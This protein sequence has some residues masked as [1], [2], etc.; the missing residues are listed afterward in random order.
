MCVE[1]SELARQRKARGLTRKKFAEL[2]GI[3]PS[4]LGLVE[5]GHVRPWP[6]L[7]ADAARLLGVGEGEL[8]RQE[9]VRP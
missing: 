4:S 3:A 1:A 7:R 8:F 9:V 6:K 2:L 5:N